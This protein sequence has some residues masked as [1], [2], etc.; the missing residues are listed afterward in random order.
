MVDKTF[1]FE[2]LTE[3]EFRSTFR[4]NTLRDFVVENSTKKGFRDKL[5]EGLTESQRLGSIGRLIKAAVMTI[6]EVGELME[7]WEAFRKGTLDTPCDKAEKMRALGLP[8]LTNAEEELADSLIR[9]LD[10]AEAHG[11]DIERATFVK[12]VVNSHRPHLHGGKNA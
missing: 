12:M 3:S 5:F 6:N 10:R 9:I 8:V 1:E 4:L 7:F 11:V 2:S